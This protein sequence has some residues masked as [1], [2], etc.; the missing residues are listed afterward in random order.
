MASQNNT[1]PHPMKD[2]NHQLR[3]NGAACVGARQLYHHI[4]H[5]YGMCQADFKALPAAQIDALILDYAALIER[6]KPERPNRPPSGYFA[7]AVGLARR[8]TGL[9]PTHA[10]VIGAIWPGEEP[11][12]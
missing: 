5:V 11:K 2:W 4:G 7:L 8:A 10:P 3:L 6:H 12:P 1:A 9:R